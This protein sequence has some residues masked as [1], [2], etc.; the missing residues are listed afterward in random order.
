MIRFKQ[1]Q[2]VLKS[3]CWGNFETEILDNESIDFFEHFHYACY[4]NDNKYYV[5]LSTFE[6]GEIVVELTE[7]EFNKYFELEKEYDNE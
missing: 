7:M 5:S 2:V 4:K 1:I 3:N 6:S